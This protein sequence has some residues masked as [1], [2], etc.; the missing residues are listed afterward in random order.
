MSQDEPIFFID[1]CLGKRRI[2]EALAP[3]NIRLETHDDHFSQ[4]TLDIEWIPEIGSRGWII[5]TKDAAI[6]R[7][8]IERQTVAQANL[9]MFTLASQN[10]SGQEMAEIFRLAIPH[11]KEFLNTN[12]PPFIA[13]I[14]RDGTVSE[15]KN[16]TA[17]LNEIN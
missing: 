12:P 5:L 2:I 16:A 17:L 10:L 3:L 15:W 13:K 8:Q 7:N 6:G 11:I 1:R 4:T 9:R 14:Y